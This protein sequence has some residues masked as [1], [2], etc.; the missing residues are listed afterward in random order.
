MYDREGG[1]IN[2]P[3]MRTKENAIN[4]GVDGHA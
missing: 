1:Y 3:G 4:A 2:V